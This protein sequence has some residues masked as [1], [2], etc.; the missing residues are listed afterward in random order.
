MRVKRVYVGAFTLVCAQQ[1]DISL[2]P[3]A[4]GAFT[5]GFKIRK[6]CFRRCNGKKN[7]FL[8]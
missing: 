3:P 5:S 6:I 4:K 2:V 8:F 1:Q 7:I